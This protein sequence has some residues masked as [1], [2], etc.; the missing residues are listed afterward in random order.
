MRAN[1]LFT[2]ASHSGLKPDT[3]PFEVSAL[4]GGVNEEPYSHSYH[5]QLLTSVKSK[6]LFEN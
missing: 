1:T 6:G 3:P 4:K 2:S 5:P